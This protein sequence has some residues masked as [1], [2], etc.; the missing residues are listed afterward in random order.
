MYA[1][2][3]FSYYIFD[4]VVNAMLCVFYL[5]LDHTKPKAPSVQSVDELVTFDNELASSFNT[6]S[7]TPTGYAILCAVLNHHFK[8]AA[9]LFNYG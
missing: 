2:C 8:N 7:Y 5:E 3:Y 4:Y 9:Y 6:A 1:S